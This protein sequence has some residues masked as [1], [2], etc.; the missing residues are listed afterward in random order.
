MEL[1]DGTKSQK[2]QGHN[3]VNVDILSEENKTT[4]AKTSGLFD[5]ET[6]VSNSKKKMQVKF[7][8]ED[9]KEI[10]KST[11]DYFVHK[12]AKSLHKTELKISSK[13]SPFFKNNLTVKHIC[14]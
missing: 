2:S 6:H 1:D 11:A 10:M 4:K 12:F 3:N 13:L 7:L 5:K 14:W 8:K 9:M